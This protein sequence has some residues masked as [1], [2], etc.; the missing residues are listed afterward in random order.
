MVPK[1][2]LTSTATTQEKSMAIEAQVGRL[3]RVT[4][5][6]QCSFVLTDQKVTR[7]DKDIQVMK[8][9]LSR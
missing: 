3:D 4:N 5:D 9:Y 7:L 8:E 2:D 6:M 1:P